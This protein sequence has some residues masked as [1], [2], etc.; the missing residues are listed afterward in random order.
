MALDVL[1]TR[2]NFM[3]DK[4]CR[5]HVQLVV[6]SKGNIDEEERGVLPVT[7]LSYADLEIA[8]EMV[9]DST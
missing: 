3:G 5:C 4:L 1:T 6:S 7:D 2:V 9:T 8:E